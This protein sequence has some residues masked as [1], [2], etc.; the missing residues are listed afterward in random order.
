MGLRRGIVVEEL[1][2]LVKHLDRMALS[3]KVRQLGK[4]VKQK[5]LMLKTQTLVKE[6]DKF[7]I[8][9]LIILSGILMWKIKN[10]I[11]KSLVKRHL[12][13]YKNFLKI[14]MFKEL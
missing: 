11:I 6:M 7:I 12:V 2:K 5:E 10:F 14:K 4:M 13:K 8:M 1:V 3:L 9:S